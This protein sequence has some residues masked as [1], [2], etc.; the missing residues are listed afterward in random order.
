MDSEP[1]GGSFVSKVGRRYGFLTVT[2]YHGKDTAG[3]S[4]YKCLC[5]CGKTILKSTSN[6]RLNNEVKYS[7]GCQM[8]SEKRVSVED[9][10]AK[11][12]DT[13]VYEIVQ[14]RVGSGSSWIMNCQKHGH[15]KIRYSTLLT[16]KSKC[17]SC[18]SYGFNAQKPSLF[19]INELT[20]KGS[21]IA[22]KYGITQ[23]NLA[24]RLG[25][26]VR[27]TEIEIKPIFVVSLSG[28]DAIE[29]EKIFKVIFDK[30]HLTS[31][32]I[33]SGYTETINPIR[34]IEILNILRYIESN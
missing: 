2:A 17:P 25:Q 13:S 19:Y 10:C 1:K 6:L 32:H 20:S 30:P 21:V 7:C 16:G 27:N 14:P 4:V 15:F 28:E 29:L 24:K 18:R 11:V 8:N 9:M 31:K 26:I 33:P 5:H 22:Y 12:A 3:K 34:I 23:Q